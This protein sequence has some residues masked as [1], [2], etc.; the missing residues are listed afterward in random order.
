MA[1]TMQTGS[2]TQWHFHG[3]DRYGAGATSGDGVAVF[4]DREGTLSV[5]RAGYEVPCAVVARLFLKVGSVGG[6]Q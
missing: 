4:V 5:S 2:N 3:A 1:N 6:V